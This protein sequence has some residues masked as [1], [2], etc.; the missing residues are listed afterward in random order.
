M[1][2]ILEHHEINEIN[3]P[4]YIS[5]LKSKKS[6]DE[7]YII[8]FGER[9]SIYEKYCYDN[10]CY[11]IQIDFINV[12]NKFADLVKTSFYLEQF[13]TNSDYLHETRPDI[14][15]T[16]L[17]DQRIYSELVN[18]KRRTI[19]ESSRLSSLGRSS[20]MDLAHMYE[21][22]FYKSYKHLCPY[23]NIKWQYSDIREKSYYFKD[24]NRP[25]GSRKANDSLLNIGVVYATRKLLQVYEVSQDKVGIITFSKNNISHLHDVFYGG[26]SKWSEYP[27][28]NIDNYLTLVDIIFNDNDKLIDLMMNLYPISK[29]YNKLSENYRRIF[30]NESF[31]YMIQRY[32][33]N[34]NVS[35]S[36]HIFNKMVSFINLFREYL[37]YDDYK[38]NNKI[39]KQVENLYKL[40]KK[41][42]TPEQKENISMEIAGLEQNED[43][44]KYHLQPTNTNRRDEI[45]RQINELKITYEDLNHFLIVIIAKTSVTLDIYF[46]LRMYSSDDQLTLSYFGTE[47]C[48]S[49][50]NYL[51]NIVNICSL[52]YKYVCPTPSSN[53]DYENV[54]EVIISKTIDLNKYFLGNRYTLPY[55]RME[56][57][58]VIP[59]KRK[60]PKRRAST[61]N[62][63][64]RTTS[65]QKLSSRKRNGT[66]KKT[67]TTRKRYTV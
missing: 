62:M 20:M 55:P 4:S 52:E 9:H 16:I 67:T 30:T 3:G 64:K 15:E 60:T 39:Y 53:N 28:L 41:A 18:K 48:K 12:L 44:I 59:Y 43:Y 24:K 2:L 5:C 66:N 63:Y 10:Q 26:N 8:L 32:D 36:T 17:N 46:I 35:S 6:Y 25:I 19:K 61:G 14:E 49:V 1:P 57:S 45:V 38:Y 56:D 23:K 42:T 29:Q 31:R 37:D 33:V 65:K 40:L 34:Y 21:S 47:H 58:A 50:T 27:N 11:D 51:C 13:I 22:C 54:N 7:R